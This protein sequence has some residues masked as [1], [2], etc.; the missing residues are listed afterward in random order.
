MAEPLDL[1]TQYLSEECT[2]TISQEFD[3]QV[4]RSR[5]TLQKHDFWHFNWSGLGKIMLAK[6]DV[7]YLKVC[8]SCWHLEVLWGDIQKAQQE[9][10]IAGIW[11]IHIFYV[12][13]C[14]SCWHLEV[15]WVSAGQATRWHPEG[16]AGIWDSQ[17]SF[18]CVPGTRDPCVCRYYR[19]YYLLHSV[20]SCSSH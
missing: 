20:C 5:S 11:N 1:V 8:W 17:D 6:H 10:G 2:L 13:V 14:W 19:N 3:H 9:S 18:H 12:Q 4:Q 16:W 7:I 15:L